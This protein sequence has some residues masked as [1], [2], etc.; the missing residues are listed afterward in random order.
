[1]K[2]YA[3]EFMGT[4]P[5]AF[6]EVIFGISEK[7]DLYVGFKS[8]K[9]QEPELYDGMVFPKYKY[10]NLDHFAG[11]L[12]KF[13]PEYFFFKEP[14]EVESLRYEHLIGQVLKNFS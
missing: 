7:D 11:V 8:R 2:V 5:D 13:I 3:V 14:L 6:Q 10:R 9:D 12:G 1:M 4:E